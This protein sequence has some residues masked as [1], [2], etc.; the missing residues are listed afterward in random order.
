MFPA[1]K[2]RLIALLKLLSLV[3]L[4]AGAIIIAKEA[5]LQTHLGTALLR[6]KNLGWLA[7]V[8]FIL[9]YNIA[10][11][12]FVPASLLTIKGGCLFGLFWGSVYV[13]IGATL[14]AVI[15]F[16]VGRYL[17][18]DW[19]A[20]QIAHHPK[21]K[22]IE[23]AISKEGWK[24]VLLTRLSPIF[25]FN[26]LNYAFGITQISLRD[27]VFGSLGMIPATIMYV[28]FGSLAM[29]LTT[30]TTPPPSI[31]PQT[32]LIQRIIQFVGIIATI[33]VTVSSAR[34]AQKALHQSLADNT[35]EG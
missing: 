13:L 3:I 34:L 27:Y 28:Y 23:E 2:P 32:Q 9:V 30:M 31:S 22:A 19:V 35:R 24:I 4:V 7:P 10:T 15:A 14:G 5:D 16:L 6:I 8:V 1:K 33:A 20:R 29:D 21:F 25:P 11:L 17:S 18:Q 26:L 12:L